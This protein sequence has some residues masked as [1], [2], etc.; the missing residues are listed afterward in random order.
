EELAA[1]NYRQGAPEE[2]GSYLRDRER[3]E[4][5][6]R[7]FAFWDGAQSATRLA[8]AFS[9]KQIT[10]VE[11]LDSGQS[12]PLARLD[13]LLIGGIYPAHNEDRV[14]VKHAEVPPILVKARIET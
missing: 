8:V 12:L 13:P 1:L 9:G 7:P 10:R 14:L 5:V 2:P 11:N 6:S 3:V 4:V